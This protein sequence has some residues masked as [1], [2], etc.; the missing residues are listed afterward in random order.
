MLIFLKEIINYE[1]NYGIF[2]V[3]LTLTFVACG[4]NEDIGSFLDKEKIT[5]EFT[6]VEEDENSPVYRA[7][8][9]K[10][11]SSDSFKNS[12]KTDVLEEKYIEDGFDII[13]KD[14]ETIIIG[15]YDSN[16]YVYNIHNF[17]D[18]KTELS[19]LVSVVSYEELS[20]IYLLGIL[21]NV[22]IFIK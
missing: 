6:I 16:T 8:V 12:N 5:S 14:T 17:D 18:T 19:I 4:K 11:M 3:I 10:K 9:F 13:Y 20:K 15:G 2:L 22:K 21:K 7:L 1:K